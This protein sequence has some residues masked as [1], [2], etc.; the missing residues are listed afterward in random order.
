[1]ILD[2]GTANLDSESEK[3]IIKDL[4]TISKN[5]TCIVVTHKIENYLG[6]VNK[7][8]ELSPPTSSAEGEIVKKEEEKK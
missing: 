8:I 4:K 7:I 2:E 5:R 6:F 1:M 3:A